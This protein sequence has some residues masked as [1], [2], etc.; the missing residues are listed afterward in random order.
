MKRLHR[1]VS[2]LKLELL[3]AIAFL[4]LALGGCAP[5]QP[6]AVSTLAG[7]TKTGSGLFLLDFNFASGQATGVH[8]LKSTGSAKLDATS[9]KTFMKWRA[10]PR[11]YT[12]VKVPLTYTLRGA[13]L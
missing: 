5:T 3:F 13:D 6:S 10:K 7:H 2:Q 12:H 11:T 1:A 9:I 4:F 8:I